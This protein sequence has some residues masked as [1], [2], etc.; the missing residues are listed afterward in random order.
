MLLSEAVARVI[1]LAGQVRAYYDREL[2]RYHRDYP[3]VHPDE[4]EPVAPPVEGELRAYLES[5]PGD[6][7][8]GL[9]TIM[10]LGRY[11]YKVASLAENFDL[12]KGEFDRSEQT[13]T[14][15]L[16]REVPLAAYL[17]DGIEELRRHDLDVDR[18]F[19]E[20]TSIS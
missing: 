17:E 7:I 12:W 16:L 11:D 3:I 20:S 9:V 2:P 5:L 8:A 15:E 1:D 13:A 19:L 18:L 14:R 10:R 6:I 4:V